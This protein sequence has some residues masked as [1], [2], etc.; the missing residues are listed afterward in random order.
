MTW[1][2]MVWLV[3]RPFDPPLSTRFPVES[4]CRT[5]LSE[6]VEAYGPDVITKADCSKLK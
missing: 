4:D 2:L 3:T 6:L 1:I 5:F